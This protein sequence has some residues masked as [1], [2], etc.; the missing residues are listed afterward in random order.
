MRGDDLAC[1]L[2]RT[3]GAFRW[4]PG[5]GIFLASPASKS[6]NQFS[7]AVG[8][9]WS[10]EAARAPQCL[11]TRSSTA[12]STT[13]A[14]MRF[15]PRQWSAA[16]LRCVPPSASQRT[17]WRLAALAAPQSACGAPRGL[18]CCLPPLPCAD[19]S[20]CAGRYSTG[21]WCCRRTSLSCCPRAA[22]CPRHGA[23]PACCS[24]HPGLPAWPWL[25]VVLAG[26]QN[27]WRAIGVQQ[28]RGWVHYA[29]HRPEPHIM[30]F[31]WA[32]PATL[33]VVCW[34]V[35]QPSAR[36]RR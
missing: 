27:E 7:E 16:R 22:C 23:R 12:R 3:G 6:G 4:R 15:G 29:I 34:P 14:C 35:A 19:I 5:G 24:M 32:R 26:V 8:R 2:G 33:I 36:I 31:R 1:L 21:T 30:L 20:Y 28:S 10:G 25:T 17:R 9:F 11:P 18:Q 13:T